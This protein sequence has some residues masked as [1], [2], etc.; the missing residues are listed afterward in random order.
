M[1]YKK[2]SL[3]ASPFRYFPEVEKASEGIIT[4]DITTDFFNH[5]TA[6]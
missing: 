4:I 3:T 2:I 5:L 1:K 6:L